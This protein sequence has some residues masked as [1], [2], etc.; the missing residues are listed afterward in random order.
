MDKEKKMQKFINQESLFKLIEDL[1]ET[2]DE[3]ELKVISD[4]INKKLRNREMYTA[5]QD[6][7]NMAIKQNPIVNKLYDMIGGKE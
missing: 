7:L 5:R 2:Y 3:I 1:F 4:V 6:T